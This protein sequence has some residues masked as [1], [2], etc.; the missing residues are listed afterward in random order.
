MSNAKP[1][2]QNPFLF[3]LPMRSEIPVLSAAEVTARLAARRA[4][5]P[6]NYF[7]FFSSWIGGI[8]TDPAAMV[9]RV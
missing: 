9:S 7:A 5:K 1:S 2:L 4:E 3:A 8:T 6:N